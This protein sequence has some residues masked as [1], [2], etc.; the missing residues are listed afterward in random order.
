MDGC[1][2]G[3]STSS[4]PPCDDLHRSCRHWRMEWMKRSRLFVRRVFLSNICREHFSPSSPPPPAPR[5]CGLA[6][7][8]FFF[9][10]APGGS[11]GG[12]EAHLRP[13]AGPSGSKGGNLTRSSG[14][15]SLQGRPPLQSSK[16]SGLRCA[17][18]GL[19]CTPSASNLSAR[20]LLRS[21][22]R[23]SA[24]CSLRWSNLFRRCSGICPGGAARLLKLKKPALLGRDPP[25]PLAP[26]KLPGPGSLSS[27]ECAPG[28]GGRLGAAAPRRCNGW[29][30]GFPM[31]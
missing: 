30:L 2:A 21:R 23:C 18:P 22:A 29:L 12:C 15:G 11:I 25:L 13:R 10:R 4:S 6:F 19:A 3:G 27:P 28:R 16:S 24:R 31:E 5:D 26:L 7:A 9:C 17:R 20:L 14:S 1:S 8:C